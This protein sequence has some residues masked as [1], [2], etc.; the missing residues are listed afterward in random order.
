MPLGLEL[1]GRAFMR[2]VRRGLYA[3]KEIR[4]GNKVSE[5]GGNKTRRTWKPNVHWKRVYSQALEKML[6]IRMTTH[7]LR[8]I[9]KAGGIDEYLL[10]TPEK[11]LNSDV[12][13]YWREHIQ[14]ALAAQLQPPALPSGTGVEAGSDISSVE[15]FE[16]PS[17]VPPSS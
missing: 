14:K 3:G 11:K 8:C 16:T 9:D 12:G 10:N 2:R 15:S 17:Q 4:F 1:V 7:A 6:R 13:M 5:D